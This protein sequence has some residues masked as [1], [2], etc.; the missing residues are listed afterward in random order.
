MFDDLEA[1]K[2]QLAEYRLSIYGK[3]K[4][5]WS[6]LAA[7]VVDNNLASTNVRWMIQV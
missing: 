5:E 1:S 7:W 6:K 2:Y 4:T 3:S